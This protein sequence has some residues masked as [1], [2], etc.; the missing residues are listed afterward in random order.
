MSTNT[1]DEPATRKRKLSRA[2]LDEPE[3]EQEQIDL[4]FLN[5]SATTLNKDIDKDE[6]LYN[7]PHSV[8]VVVLRVVNEDSAR[9]MPQSAFFDREKALSSALKVLV[10]FCEA[11]YKDYKWK[12]PHALS[13]HCI[14]RYIAS[15]AGDD[16][17]PLAFADVIRVS[18][19][20]AKDYEAAHHEV[21]G[22]GGDAEMTGRIDSWRY[23]Q[24]W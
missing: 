17:P 14:S 3:V 24:R 7:G 10:Q 6:A 21:E 12:G 1:H 22:D 20:D 15:E 11:H 23:P 2:G 9:P 19:F 16:G 5:G 4:S 18:I 13:S 8:H